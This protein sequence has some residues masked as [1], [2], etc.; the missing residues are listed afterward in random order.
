MVLFRV[1]SHHQFITALFIKMHFL[2]NEAADIFLS[3]TVDFN[4][5]KEN[6][7]KTNIFRRVK[8]LKD[9]EAVR[10][11]LSKTFD[12]RR[13]FTREVPN[14][15]DIKLDTTYDS[16]YFG[17]NI[18][19]NKLFYYY[20]IT[21]QQAPATYSIEEGVGSYLIDMIGAGNGD[22]F[23]H[24][25]YKS[26][27]ILAK[28][29]NQFLYLKNSTLYT[30]MRKIIQIPPATDNIKKALTDIYGGL[31]L[32]DERIIFI[33]QCFY[34]QGL[35]SN[36]IEL[37]NIISD[38]VGRDNIIVKTH[39]R[40]TEDNFS[41]RGFKVMEQTTI[42]WEVYS[43][44]DGLKNKICVSI[45]STSLLLPYCLYRNISPTFALSKLFV[46]DTNPFFDYSLQKDFVDKAKVEINSRSRQLF[47]PANIVELQEHL[48]YMKGL[49]K[50]NQ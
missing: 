38:L 2:E 43:M 6:L 19:A 33:A 32:P 35:P 18:L 17:H 7:S 23:D 8:I 21:C 1:T 9:K 20:L 22:G 26:N 10:F 45:F 49:I 30:P 29:K 47:I 31:K 14:M 15:W 4:F 28:M 5:V 16:Y 40:A 48:A 46:G 34:F 13:E 27:S 24:S 36:E 11:Y 42:P 12:E 44:L 50:W 41:Y 3:D 25:Y 39:P 37:I